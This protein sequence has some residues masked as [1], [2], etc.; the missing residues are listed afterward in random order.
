VVHV[1]CVQEVEAV[2]Y[3][4]RRRKKQEKGRHVEGRH[5]GSGLVIQVGYQVWC[6]KQGRSDVRR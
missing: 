5:T 6:K 4:S 1:D 3:P 2:M